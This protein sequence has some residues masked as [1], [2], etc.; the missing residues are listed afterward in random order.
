MG[1]YAIEVREILARTVIADGDTYEQAEKRVK[2]SVKQKRITLHEEN[3]HYDY[4][5]K[6]D[7]KNYLEIFGEEEFNVLE[8]CSHL[9]PKEIEL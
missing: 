5:F 7:T 3:S 9:I 1:K 6:D 8:E 4:D 2:E